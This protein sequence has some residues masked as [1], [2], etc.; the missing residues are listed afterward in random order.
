MS[1]ILYY[2]TRTPL[3]PVS[4]PIRSRTPVIAILAT[5][6]SFSWV[7]TGGLHHHERHASLYVCV[8]RTQCHPSRVLQ[9]KTSTRTGPQSGPWSRA[10]SSS[11][12]HL[13]R[14]HHCARTLRGDRATS[15][16]TKNCL[17]DTLRAP[18]PIFNFEGNRAAT[19]L[20]GPLRDGVG[21]QKLGN[22]CSGSVR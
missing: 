14:G 13:Q 16:R 20:S 6:H 7:A 2:L 18:Q 4:P 12:R 3:R 22:S 11:H 19:G 10:E 15:Q 17:E 8:S 9:N 21:F 5:S 1:A